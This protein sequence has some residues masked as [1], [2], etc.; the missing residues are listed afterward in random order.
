MYF[1][2]CTD[3]RSFKNSV[4]FVSGT[5]K[6]E[7]IQSQL[8]LVIRSFPKR[9]LKSEVVTIKFQIH[10]VMIW[11]ICTIYEFWLLL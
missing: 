8:K 3:L 1:D 9:D 7:T 2:P 5:L 10:A 6:K 11:G 4:C